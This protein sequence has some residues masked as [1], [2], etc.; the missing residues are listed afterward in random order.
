MSNKDKT[1]LDSWLENDEFK[2]QALRNR[3]GG[4]A[5]LQRSEFFIDQNYDKLFLH[6]LCKMMR[7]ALYLTYA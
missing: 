1:Y 2:Q 5:F 7:H 4:G 3:G 6:F